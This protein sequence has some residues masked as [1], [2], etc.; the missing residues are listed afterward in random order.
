MVYSAH[1]KFVT[2]WLEKRAGVKT[3][4]PEGD[5]PRESAEEVPS[6]ASALPPTQDSAAVGGTEIPPTVAA[7]EAEGAK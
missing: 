3:T 6:T 4:G 1:E 5:E 2:K 7:V